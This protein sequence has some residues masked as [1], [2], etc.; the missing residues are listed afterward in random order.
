MT[1]SKPNSTESLLVWEDNLPRNIPDPAEAVVKFRESEEGQKLL[2]TLLSNYSAAKTQRDI[3]DRQWKYNLAMYNNMQYVDFIRAG[4]FK[5]EL[6][7]KP[8][9]TNKERITVNRI[10]PAVRAEMS[11][12]LSQKPSASV[13]PA[14]SDDSDMFAAMAGEQVWEHLYREGHFQDVLTD[15]AFW[16]SI[17]GNGFIKAYWDQGAY[18]TDSED[19]GKICYESVTPFN[20]LVPDLRQT[21]IEKQPYV[22]NVYT[23]TPEWL[24]MNFPKEL[25]GVSLQASAN[26][27]NELLDE[28]WLG[29]QGAHRPDPDVCM[30]YE[31]WIKPGAL[32]ALPQGGHVVIAERTIIGYTEGEFYQHGQ[33]PFAHIGHIYTGKFYRRSVLN[34]LNELQREYNKTRTNIN[35]AA[36][37]MGKPQIVAQKGSIATAKMSNETGLIIEYRPGFPKPEPMPMAEVPAYVQ[38]SLDRVLLDIEDISGQHQVSKGQT[39]PGVTAATA[40]SFLQEKDDSY[41]T[42]TYFSL[43]SAVEKIAKQSLYLAVQM[44]D[45]P[46]LVKIVGDDNMF[47]TMLLAG[48]EIKRGT[49]IR[50]EP[51]SALPTS[52]AARQAFIMDLMNG[53][54]IPPEAGLELLEI[55]GPTKLM[56]QLGQ[57]KRQAQRENVRMKSLTE[58]AIMEHQLQFMS[59]AP[60]TQDG[61]PPAEPGPVVSVND[62]DNH[63]VH[64]EVHN[65]FRRSQ[66][67]EFLP[68]EVKAQ[69]EQHVQ[70]HKQAMAQENIQNLLM[71]IPTDGTVPGPAGV[72]DDAAMEGMEAAMPGSTETDSM[73]AEGGL[74]ADESGAPP[75][76]E[77]PIA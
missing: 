48:A 19:T 41:L 11:R 40:I 50:I 77:A 46:R 54:F 24:Y 61:M 7:Q 70:M 57:D 56:E 8:K 31:F 37:K 44:W 13:I 67:F 75:T 2:A 28:T 49:D 18:D 58:E 25:E 22:I 34:S 4:A 42:T 1:E 23:K 39:P 68:D 30:V 35:N 62:W 20:L 33:Y 27:Q 72:M 59:M 21:D 66:I 16:T 3:E 12:L 52:K 76:E 43:E 10:E 64:I 9:V 55:G 63:A 6:L 51:G 53:G 45:V 69:F 15:A 36:N 26:T 14:S 38:N 32:K 29:L 74:P 17:T 47:D 73:G 71:N 5:G 65:R 60:P